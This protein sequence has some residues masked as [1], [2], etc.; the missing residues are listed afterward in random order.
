MAALL[1]SHCNMAWKS[2]PCARASG[3]LSFDSP[4]CFISAKCGS[5]V[6][7]RF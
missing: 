1:F 5:S 4:C 7:V 6:L 2:F 3:Y